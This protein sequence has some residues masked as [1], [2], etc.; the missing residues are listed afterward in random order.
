MVKNSK[1]NNF[2]TAL[3]KYKSDKSDKNFLALLKENYFNFVL[4][5]KCS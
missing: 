4:K 5:I 3:I 2:Q 1:H